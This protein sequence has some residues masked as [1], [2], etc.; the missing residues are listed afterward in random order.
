MQES[1][2]KGIIYLQTGYHK[3]VI[4]K[5]R[6]LLGAAKIRQNI[7]VC[8]KKRQKDCEVEKIDIFPVIFQKTIYLCAAPIKIPTYRKRYMHK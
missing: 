1:E 5:F 7:K 3:S 8:A 2:V 6:V 4:L